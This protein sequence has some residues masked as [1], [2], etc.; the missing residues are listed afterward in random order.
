MADQRIVY[1]EEMVGSGHPTKSDTLNRFSLIEHNNDGTHAKKVTVASATSPDIWTGSFNGNLIDYTGTTTAT[2]FANAPQAGEWRQLRLAAA[3]PFT[4][5]ANMLIQGYNSGETYTGAAGDKVIVIAETTTQFRLFIDKYAGNTTIKVG[6][7]TRDVSTASGT[8]A[9]T[10]LGGRPRVLFILTGTSGTSD[11]SI[12][13]GDTATN[14][15][16]ADYHNVAADQFTAT[17]NLVYIIQS[18]ATN[19]YTGVVSSFDA[20]GFTISWTKAGSPTGVYTLRYFA[21]L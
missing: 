1:T 18:P 12:G 10:G 20:D 8:Q 21:I 19:T 9:V 13:W 2:G 15:S 11:F 3:A 14:M 16:I 7:F 5:G 4:A 6:T 17:T